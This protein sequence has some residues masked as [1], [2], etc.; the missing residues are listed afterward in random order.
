MTDDP[1]GNI[2]L[3]AAPLGIAGVFLMALFERIVPVLPSHGLYAAIGVAAAEGAWGLPAAIILS[4]LGSGAGAFATYRLGIRL[5]AGEGRA[6]RI[7]R[8]LRRRDRLGRYLRGL[9][10]RSGALPFVAQL[11]PAAR[12][13]APLIAGA[14]PHDWRRLSVATLAGL[15]VWNTTFIAIG[16]VMVQLGGPTNATVV[17][18]TI[19]ALLAGFFIVTRLARH[20]RMRLA[21]TTPAYR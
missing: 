19:L 1:L 13:V 10:R 5:A 15:T 17:S 16:F 7:R 2:L 21:S 18:A 12:L 11:L 6:I 8:L 3:F 4:V 9:Q 20:R 14:T